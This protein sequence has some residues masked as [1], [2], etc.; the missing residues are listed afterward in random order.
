MILPFLQCKDL[1][2]SHKFY[3]EKLGFTSK[4]LMGPDGKLQTA[5]I[6]YGNSVM[7]GLGP[8]L[9]PMTERGQGVNIMLYPDDFDID[10]YYQQVKSKGVAIDYDIKTEYWGD[11]IFSVKDPDGYYL[12]FGKTVKQVS[13]EEAQAL[14]AKNGQQ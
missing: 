12:T 2:A 6:N 10:A 9:A 11:R 5:L 4:P 13:M 1:E 3:T 8:D 7:M 14:L